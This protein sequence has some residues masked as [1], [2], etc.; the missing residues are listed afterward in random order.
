MN[1]KETY[2]PLSSDPTQEIAKCFN[3]YL[4]SR[5]QDRIINKGEFDK[6]ALP[7]G[8]ETL[9]IYFV[10]NVHKDPVKLRPIVACTNRPTYT[11]SGHIDRLLQPHMKAV[12]SYQKFIGSNTYNSETRVPPRAYMVTSDIESLYTT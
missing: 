7:D 5:L 8:I 10:L 2:K 11:A 12:K 9:T 1:D 4:E 6:L 3:Q